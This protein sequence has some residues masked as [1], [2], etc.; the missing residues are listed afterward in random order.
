[1]RKSDEIKENSL[2]RLFKTSENES[3][4]HDEI[5]I[6]IYTIMSDLSKA[7]ELGIREL[8]D[9]LDK[10][11]SEEYV[12]KA[13]REFEAPVYSKSYNSTKLAGNIDLLV[14]FVATSKEE[15]TFEGWKDYR[16]TEKV[17]WKGIDINSIALI[18]EIKRL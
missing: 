11:D 4:M 8:S 2:V 6:W 3:A 13:I 12:I 14:R 15:M 1:M 10:Y 18:I 9:F 7:K 5:A 16:R 17:T